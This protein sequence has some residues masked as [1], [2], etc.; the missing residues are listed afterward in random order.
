MIRRPLPAL[1]AVA[2]LLSVTPAAAV[3]STQKPA[4]PSSKLDFEGSFD[5]PDSKVLLRE[6]KELWLVKADYTGAL[7]KFNAAID[8]DPDD[9]E[10]RLQRGHFFETLSTIVIPADKAKFKARAQVDFEKITASDP[11]SLIAGIARDGLT[12]LAG[13][14]LLTQKRVSCPETARD[15]HDRADQLYGAQQYA[16]SVVEYEKAATACPAAVSYWV[17][18]ADSYYALED[19]EKA[20]EVFT[21]ALTVDSWIREAHRFLSANEVHLKNLDGAVHH[22]ALAVVSDPI[23]EAGWSALRAYA[24]AVGLGW[25]RVYGNR[26]ADA[27]SAD[28][29]YWGM[30]AAAKT[31]AKGAQAGS[32]SALALER[33]A[34]K[35]ALKSMREPQPGSSSQPG[36]FWSMMSRAEDAGYLDEAIFMH[37][38]DAPLAAEYPAFRE[39]NADRLATYLKT[40]IL[41]E[42]G[43]GVTSSR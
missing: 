27:A 15:F 18:F 24:S 20:K 25:T 22:L 12:R 1:A 2:L 29:M 37:L 26:K 23:Y 13:E 28:G 41:Q 17:D 40:I 39:K 43:A 32:S 35:A 11:D 19:Y 6:A 38:L 30:Y 42:R 16:E 4:P 8:A 31:K 9:N 33:N 3:K 34:V 36:P 10:A 14:T 7:A 5:R 21:K